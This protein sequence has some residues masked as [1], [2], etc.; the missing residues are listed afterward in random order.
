MRKTLEEVEGLQ[1]ITH[2]ICEQR[3]TFKHYNLE[4]PNN[5][6]IMKKKMKNKGR[7]HK[8]NKVLKI[9]CPAEF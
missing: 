3:P 7:T 6:M 4:E 2:N 5:E 9:D 8:I 1:T